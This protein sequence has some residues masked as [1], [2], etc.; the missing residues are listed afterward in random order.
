MPVS[1]LPQKFRFC[2]QSLLPTE[3]F[4]FQQD[5]CSY[6]YFGI[7]FNL[8][9]IQFLE[10]L[11]SAS[12]CSF[13]IHFPF[14]ILLLLCIIMCGNLHESSSHNLTPTT[15]SYLFPGTNPENE[16]AVPK[17]SHERTLW[18]EEVMHVPSLNFKS[19]CFVHWG[20]SHAQVSI[21]LL[22]LCWSL[23]LPQFQNYWYKK[24]HLCVIC[25][26]FICRFFR[27]QSHVTFWNLTLTVPH[28]KCFFIRLVPLPAIIPDAALLCPIQRALESI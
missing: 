22:H 7:F 20:G 8:S 9:S 1:V 3:I 27:G 2:S 21:L 25:Q 18:E 5:I 16:V 14:K 19:C 13:S 24:K 15:P 11:V 17:D 4:H 10:L 28:K 26:H 6:K 23:L 12:L